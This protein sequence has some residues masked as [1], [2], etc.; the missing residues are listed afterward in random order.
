V[1]DVRRRRLT[2]PQ[3]LTLQT[4]ANQVMVQ[5][6]LRHLL[7]E[8]RDSEL[9]AR[10]GERTQRFLLALEDTLRQ[11]DEPDQVMQLVAT[12]LGEHLGVNRCAYGVVEPDELHF[13][14]TGD[15]ARGAA[16]LRGRF[17]IAALGPRATA[18]IQVGRPFVVVDADADPTLGP[19]ERALFGAIGAK[20]SVWVPLRR[21]GRFVAGIAVHQGVARHW[22]AAE[23]ELLTNVAERCWETLER[24]HAE[25][26]AARQ[27]QH[28]ELALE[29]GR[30]G[31]WEWDLASGE[32]RWSEGM[33]AVYGVDPAQGTPST[34]RFASLIVDEDRERLFGQIELLR[35]DGGVIEIEF[36]IRRPDTGELRWILA[37]GAV[38]RDDE[39]RAE[40]MTG[41]SLDNTPRKLAEH[42]LLEADA[43]KDEFLAMLAHEL[44]NP[45]APLTNALHLLGRSDSLADRERGVLAMADRQTRQLRRLVDDLLEVSRIT[46]GK[47]ALQ[48]EPMLVGK[49][50]Y[51]AVE[52]VSAEL[53]HRGQR[54]ELALPESPARVLA[55]PARIA[56][57]LENLLNN[58][59]KYTPRGG[60]IRIAVT[61]GP[62]E[63][64]VRV[65]DT[66]VGIA[67]DKI[68]FLFELF[69]QIDT[70]LDRAQGG[71]G[72]GLAMVRQ[73]VVLHGGR[74]SA[75][76][77]GLG[78]GASF[79]IVLPRHRAP[80]VPAAKSGDDASA[81]ATRG[82]P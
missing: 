50:V 39:S 45:L 73:L 14:V 48:C 76:S 72:I 47:I 42:R 34:E 28:A 5:L 36:R 74:V 16:P 6:E 60:T 11:F 27:R 49:S 62:D 3:R 69:S 35:R 24:L 7:V 20:A 68:P 81:A 77:R 75:E 55:D 59:S 22:Q 17:G 51:A 18:A 15:H 61:D 46:R 9:R 64:E 33:F 79:V 66:G 30:M 1:M 37:R 44:R 56:Q 31:V 54:I 71:L 29:A 82:A 53:E 58:A 80:S 63:V 38:L 78:E 32:R 70:T 57:V 43:R 4:L 40:L 41:V 8:Q 12:R 10:E 65:T 52:S 21:A 19:A 25:H 67:A 26:R 13:T 23:V 2:P